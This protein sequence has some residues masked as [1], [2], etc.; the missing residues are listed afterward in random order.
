MGRCPRESSLVCVVTDDDDK[1]QGGAACV[2]ARVCD[3]GRCQP[4]TGRWSPNARELVC[5]RDWLRLPQGPVPR[6]AV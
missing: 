3:N 2:N 6:L 4:R 1:R 5:E